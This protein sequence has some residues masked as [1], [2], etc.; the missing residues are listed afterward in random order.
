MAGD[1]L[2]GLDEGVGQLLHRGL[3]LFHPVGGHVERSGGV[4]AAQCGLG[5]LHGAHVHQD[6]GLAG[7]EQA[8]DGGLGGHAGLDLVL[9]H[10]GDEGGTGA[11]RDGGKLTQGHA[12]LDHHVLA[13]EVGGGTQTGHAQGLATQVGKGLD[14]GVLVGHQF[15]LARCL[16]ELHHGHDLL[17]LG[18]QVH[19]VVIEAH[20]ALHGAGQHLV[21]GVHARSFI[22]QFHVQTLGLEVP[23]CLGELGRQVNLLLVTANN[24]R[25]LVGRVGEGST[26]QGGC[27]CKASEP[28]AGWEKLLHGVSCSVQE[29]GSGPSARSVKGACFRLAFSLGDLG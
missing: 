26:A 21:L 15:H 9:L 24:D 5:L 4:G 7:L 22:E 14:L 27:E 8:R 13:Q 12:G 23:E 2:Q 25:D 28:L 10:G 29:S 20:H 3:V 19:A 16:A 11:D 18:L 6:A 1:E 17:A